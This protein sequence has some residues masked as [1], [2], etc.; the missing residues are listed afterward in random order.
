MLVERLR[1]VILGPPGVGKG[2]YASAIS[3]A[4]GIPHISTGELLRRE[5]AAGT[6]LGV[7]ARYFVERGLL[8][9]DEIVNQVLCNY[10]SLEE[11]RRGYVLDGYPRT[12]SQ[13]RFL[14]SLAPANAAVAL[15]A[16]IE[17]IVSRLAGRLYCPACGRVYHVTWRPPTREGFCDT[18]GTPLARRS[19]DDP[20]VVAKRVRIYYEE[21]S[22]VVEFYRKLGKLLEFDANVD[23]VVGVP[24]L[25]SILAERAVRIPPESY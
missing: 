24:K 6:E 3:R 10:L 5:I 11:C 21:V 2:T 16:S 22:E 19:D 15:R 9:P 18:C 23:S 8:V 14:E 4:F 7:K 12:I 1:V 17:T 13:A 20:S 25:L